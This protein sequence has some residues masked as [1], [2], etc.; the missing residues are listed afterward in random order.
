MYITE[1]TCNKPKLPPNIV[2]LE[3]R[4]YLFQDKLT[5]QCPNE[6]EFVIECKADGNWSPQ[7]YC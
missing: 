4:S 5:I 2:L 7:P 3:G 1:I 6:A